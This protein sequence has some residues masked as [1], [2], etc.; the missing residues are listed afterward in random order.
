MMKNIFI[1]G[2]TDGIGRLAA[3]KFA[4]EG[5][6]LYLHGRNE[7][8]LTALSSEIKEK[9]NSKNVVGFVADF[10][11]LNSVKTML[12]NIKKEVSNIDVL[13]NNA[14]VFKSTISHNEE[15]FDLRFVVNYFAPYLLTQELIPLLKKGIKS[16]IINL[17]SA[18]QS[19]VSYEAMSG[20][21]SISVNESYAQSKLALTMWSFHLAQ[22][23]NDI[24]VI[25]VNPGSLLNTKMANEAYGQYWS[26][27]E[28]GSDI[29]YDLA[30]SE[31]HKGLSGKYY[32]NDHGM[33][34]KA[35]A[36]AYDKKAIAKL[37]TDTQNLIYKS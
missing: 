8:K 6:S 17:S 5:H 14:G 23:H 26:P 13:I 9:T 29:I 3:F 11:D 25:A 2:A 4:S 32:D 18:A 34:A 20:E 7:E 21:K 36:N 30:L 10:S 1:T 19:P 33:Y 22:E 31:E 28:K 16:R 12:E 15:G 27:A 24:A 37:M 35:H